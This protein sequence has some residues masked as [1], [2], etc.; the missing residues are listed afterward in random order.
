[1]P[2]REF[3]AAVKGV[4]DALQKAV[5]TVEAEDDW[6]MRRPSVRSAHD[7]IVSILD[8]AD[9]TLRNDEITALL[10]KTDLR[11]RL[12]QLNARLHSVTEIAFAR[13]AISGPADRDPFEGSWINR[14]FTD[15][16]IGQVAQW[17]RCGSLE[18]R[19][20]RIAIVGGGALPQTQVFLARALGCDTVSVER[21]PEAAELSRKML[22]WTG[23]R[24]A[25]V[26]VA[27]GSDFDFGGCTIV[28]VATLVRQKSVISRQVAMTAPQATFAPRN[29]VGAHAMWRETI[30]EES[31]LSQGWRLSDAW[32]PAGSTVASHTYRTLDC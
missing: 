20:Q 10:A 22:A 7:G 2:D 17:R 18:A 24:N 1:M 12:I 29:A 13:S 27:D 26:E 16:L 25:Q 31:V 30:D 3:P 21:D 8:R 11:E 15:L 5:Q 14:G 9:R 6:D 32:V 23:V 19:R 4:A 28:A